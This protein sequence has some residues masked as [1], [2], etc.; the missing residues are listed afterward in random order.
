[1]V[2]FGKSVCLA[3]AAPCFCH[4]PIEGTCPYLCASPCPQVRPLAEAT[5][6]ESHRLPIEELLPPKHRPKTTATVARRLLSHALSLP[7]LRDRQGERE[8]REQ[9]LARKEVK[10]QRQQ[11][12]ESA[13]ND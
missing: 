1:M 12:L 13:W 9:R 3:S 7:E 4:C 6:S 2:F 8:L 5:N 11:Q 10:A